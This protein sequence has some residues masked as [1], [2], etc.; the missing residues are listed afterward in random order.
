MPKRDFQKLLVHLK[1]TQGPDPLNDH[2]PDQA[3][4]KIS[5][6]GGL[7]RIKTTRCATQTPADV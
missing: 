5:C 4:S 2:R 3:F 1:T 6:I 7:S